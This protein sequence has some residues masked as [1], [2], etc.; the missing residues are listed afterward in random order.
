MIGSVRQYVPQPAIQIL[1][2]HHTKSYN[3]KMIPIG[4]IADT[5]DAKLGIFITS[6]LSSSTSSSYAAFVVPY[7]PI[8]KGELWI[9]D[10][11]S[12]DYQVTREVRLNLSLEG[13]RYPTTIRDP[14][15]F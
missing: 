11:L 7:V 6:L 15:A 9:K 14:C 12:G 1:L 3:S 10:S 2:L 8:F 13:S 5:K 4:S